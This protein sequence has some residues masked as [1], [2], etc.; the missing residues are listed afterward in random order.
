MNLCRKI[1]ITLKIPRAGFLPYFPARCLEITQT[2]TPVIEHSSLDA[3]CIAIASIASPDFF[4]YV[5]S[6]T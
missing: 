4:V 2:S 1:P 6:Y 5:T 3:S